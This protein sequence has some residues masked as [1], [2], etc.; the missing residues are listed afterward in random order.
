METTNIDMNRFKADGDYAVKV[1]IGDQVKA[2]GKIL[3]A[4]TGEFK[5]IEV[6]SHLNIFR[7][8]KDGKEYNF[9]VQHICH[10][11]ITGQLS[12]R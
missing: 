8:E 4:K 12:I 9:P 6:V 1:T 2:A 10:G 5:I 11:I 3:V 7:V